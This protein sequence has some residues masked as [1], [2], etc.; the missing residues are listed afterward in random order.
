[1]EVI[2]VRNSDFLL[3]ENAVPRSRRAAIQHRFHGADGAAALEFQA[4]GPQLSSL[5]REANQFDC[6]TGSDIQPL[7]RLEYMDHHYQLIVI[8]SGSGGKDAAILGARTGLRV[9]LLEKDNL[10]WAVPVF[11]EAVTPFEL[12]GHAQCIIKELRRVPVSDF[13]SIFW[14]RDGRIGLL[15][16]SE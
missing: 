8:G 4:I 11:I 13:Q 5:R 14:K 9:L 2:W 15:P 7:E 10:T 12:C 6:R 3:L 16:R 1:M